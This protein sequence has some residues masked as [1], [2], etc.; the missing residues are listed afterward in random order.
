LFGSVSA[1]LRAASRVMAAGQSAH[2]RLAAAQLAG[3]SRFGPHSGLG[4]G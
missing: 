2:G 4:G 1:Q 3:L